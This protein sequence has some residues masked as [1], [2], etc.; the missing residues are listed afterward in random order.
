M[1]TLIII[2]AIICIPFVIA[3]FVKKQYNVQRSIVIDKPV[4]TVFN[5]VKYIKNQ[6]YY[7]KW[8]MSDPNKKTTETG[9]D[10]EVG[11]IYTWDSDRKN[12]GAGAQEIVRMA[13]NDRIGMELRFERPFKNTGHSYMITEPSGSSTK[14]IWGFNG[15][16]KYPMNLMNLMIDGMLGKDMDESL[17]NLKN[18]LEK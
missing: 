6:N 16:N 7:S 14:V 8:N 3:L 17:H 9:N 5:Y 1:T 12:T 10:G 13:E 4:E 15:K 18:I 11:F 2:L